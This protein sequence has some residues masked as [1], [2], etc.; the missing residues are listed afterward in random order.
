M[1]QHDSFYSNF[2]YLTKI[3]NF[4]DKKII[5]NHKTILIL[6]DKL[7]LI[8]I[9]KLIL[10]FLNVFSRDIIMIECVEIKN[11]CKKLVLITN[12]LILSKFEE[13]PIFFKCTYEYL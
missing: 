7:N 6:T 5:I 3:K 11:I 12:M 1:F 4:L 13:F 2:N 8:K 10:I 9:F